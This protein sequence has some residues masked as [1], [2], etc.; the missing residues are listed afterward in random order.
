VGSRLWAARSDGLWWRDVS[1]LNA[2]RTPVAA[3]LRLLGAHPVAGDEATLAFRL[4]APARAT[5][6][7]FDVGGRRARS[8]TREAGA[9]EHRVALDLR[10]LPAGAYLARL[11]AAG[12]VETLR[13][14]RVTP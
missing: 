4:A 2:P 1:L 3:R 13:F 7:L 8:E 9:G 6:E 10:G 5:V 12:R 14:V 11:A